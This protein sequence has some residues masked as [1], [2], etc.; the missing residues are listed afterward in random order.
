MAVYDDIEMKLG[1]LSENLLQPELEVNDP[2]KT[3]TCPRCGKK[4]R[5]FFTATSVPESLENPINFMVAYFVV[6]VMLALFIFGIEVRCINNSI[7]AVWL[8][9]V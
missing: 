6:Y 8:N 5:R 7:L 2:K 4:Q 3:F 9:I 1:R